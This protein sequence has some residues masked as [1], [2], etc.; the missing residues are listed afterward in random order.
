M[1]RA[2]VLAIATVI[3]TSAVS[4]AFAEADLILLTAALNS[5]SGAAASPWLS[6]LMQICRHAR[7]PRKAKL[8]K[9]TVCNFFTGCISVSQSEPPVLGNSEEHRKRPLFPILW[10]GG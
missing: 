9:A 8:L 4:S 1:V 7:P 3:A 2:I 6:K 5:T 10:L